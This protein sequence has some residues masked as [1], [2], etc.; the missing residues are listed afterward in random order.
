MFVEC[1][2]K[3]NVLPLDAC[4]HKRKNISASATAA[5][6]SLKIAR[7]AHA[8]ISKSFIGGTESFY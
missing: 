6:K 5:S 4:K 1:K 8:P 7:A 2:I 3:R